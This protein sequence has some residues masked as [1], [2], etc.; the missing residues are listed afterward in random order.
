MITKTQSSDPPATS[1]ALRRADDRKLAILRAAA[2]VFRERGYANAG[3]RDIASAADLS[4]A[5][6]YY[7]FSGKDEIL[8][9]CQ[10]RSLA[11][12][13]SEVGMAKS[14]KISVKEQLRRVLLT[15]ILCLLDDVEGSVAHLETEAL[16]PAL[17]TKIVEKRDQY[18]K[19]IRSLLSQG[20]ANGEFELSDTT[21]T[22]RAILGAINW[23]ARWF[24]PDG[25]QSA[26]YVAENTVAFLLNGLSPK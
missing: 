9:F 26:K 20:A 14:S 5:N 10:D 15:H 2:R 7:Y 19:S 22:A 8:Y 4:P 16:P 13:T 23:T 6:L 12:M 11:R 24:R 21:L 25:K 1:R 17:R 3:M 18:E